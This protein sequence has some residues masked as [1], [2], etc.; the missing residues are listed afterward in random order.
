MFI[1]QKDDKVRPTGGLGGLGH[2][3]R[4]SPAPR[5]APRDLVNGVGTP[6]PNP[7]NPR[8][9]SPY[10]DEN[11]T[12]PNFQT[13]TMQRPI[14]PTPTQ[15]LQQ[16]GSAPLA[17][18]KAPTKLFTMKNLGLF[19]VLTAISAGGYYYTRS[20]SVEEYEADLAED[21]D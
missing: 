4:K 18:T 12:A 2:V 7:L 16:L 6:R 19:T 21:D 3:D 15:E 10:A 13:P 1:P 9:N 14:A 17:V 20:R 11:N 5:P 8:M